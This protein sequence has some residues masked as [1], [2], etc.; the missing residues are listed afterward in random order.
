MENASLQTS[1][2][3]NLNRAIT[4]CCLTTDSFI[5]NW[6]ESKIFYLTSY[7]RDYKTTGTFWKK[8]LAFIILLLMITGAT[9]GQYFESP[10]GLTFDMFFFSILA[11]VLL[12]WLKIMP[13]QKYTKAISWDV[14]IT[15]ACSF[16]ISKALQNSGAAESLGPHNN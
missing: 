4:W 9:V 7:I 3:L 15:I 14:L 1:T 11:A 10:A 8:W 16:A 6:G 2:S 12:I 5:Q 13:H